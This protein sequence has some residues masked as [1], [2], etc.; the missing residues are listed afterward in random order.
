MG[1]RNCCR[2][3]VANAVEIKNDD[4]TD[5]TEK[6]KAKVQLISPYFKQFAIDLN[7]INNNKVSVI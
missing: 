6:E 7:E 2:N 3:P 5:N 4:V 1:S